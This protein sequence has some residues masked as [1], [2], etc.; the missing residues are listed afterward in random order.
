MVCLSD[1]GSSAV[2]LAKVKCL[3]GQLLVSKS[4]KCHI[5]EKSQLICINRH[6]S[7]YKS[8]ELRIQTARFETHSAR[9]QEHRFLFSTLPEGGK[10][11]RGE[12]FTKEPGLRS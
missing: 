1:P 12:M 3:W 5:H 8:N 2:K 11:V 9:V 6:L 10:G 7:G 4:L